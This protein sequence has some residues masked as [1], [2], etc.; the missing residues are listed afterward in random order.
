VHAENLEP[1]GSGER[2]CTLQQARRLRRPSE[3]AAVLAASRPT[4]MRSAGTWLSVTAAWVP[5][6]RAI[7]RIGVT[8]SKRMAR[9][10]IDRALV[11]RIAR[12]AFRRSA[13]AIERAAAG[14]AVRVDISVRLKRPLGAPGDPQRLPLIGLRRALRAEVEQLLAAVIARLAAVPAHV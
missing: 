3:F 13:D 12:E 9:R 1:G 7:A 8:V 6:E 10:S 11:K 2:R 14:A 5:A 4:S